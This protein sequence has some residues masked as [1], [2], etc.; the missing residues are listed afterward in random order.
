MSYTNIK[1]M[2]STPMT[3]SPS[4][5]NRG[6]GSPQKKMGTFAGN[7]QE[8]GGV[9][10][11]HRTDWISHNQNRKGGNYPNRGMRSKM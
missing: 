5:K 9:W 2:A 6:T 7:K 11:G 1:R 10:P 4:N 3:A 8:K